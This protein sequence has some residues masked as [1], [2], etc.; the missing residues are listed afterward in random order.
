MPGSRNRASSI[1]GPA[2]ALTST[3]Q[4]GSR[5]PESGSLGSVR[6]ALSNERPYRDRVTQGAEETIAALNAERTTAW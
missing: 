5:V 3:T 6:G 2:S 1:L 4:G